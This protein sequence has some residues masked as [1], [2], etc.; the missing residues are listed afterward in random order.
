MELKLLKSTNSV[1]IFELDKFG[2]GNL[3]R[4]SPNIFS[5]TLEVNG[6]PKTLSLEKNNIFS[7]DFTLRNE[8]DEELHLGLGVHYRGKVN[9]SN[10]SFV[11]ISFFEEE[12]FGIIHYDEE[13]YEFFKE[14]N[15]VHRLIPVTDD[16]SFSCGNEYIN[17]EIS[18]ELRLIYENIEPENT[19][20]KIGNLKGLNPYVTVTA[21]TC[22]NVAWEVDY[23]IYSTLITNSI[24]PVNYIT[25]FFNASKTLFA[26]DGVE[27]Q[28]SDLVF[29]TTGFS[30]YFGYSLP[31]VSCNTNL[32]L[33]LTYLIANYSLYYS[34]NNKVPKGDVQ[35]LLAISY[36]CLSGGR[37][38]VSQ[39]IGGLCTSSKFLFSQVSLPF[40]PSSS[41]YSWGVNVVTHEQG[42]MFGSQHTHACA[43]NG[44]NTAIDRC[45]YYPFSSTATTA[46]GPSCSLSVTVPYPEGGTIMSYC[47]N[48]YF[49]SIMDPNRQFVGINFSLGFGPQP[50][51]VIVNHINKKAN[52]SELPTSWL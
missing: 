16:P 2:L 29:W 23:D 32:S 11:A 33:A 15:L 50:Q 46:G 12:V 37:A 7:N 30:P 14:S 49:P 47:Q 42:H 45:A 21:N 36:T 24:D 18:E 40:T 52:P 41:N 26:N 51:Q 44:N 31:A 3:C 9:E 5:L 38:G 43:W 28:L 25:S 22:I 19:Q 34:D 27:V 35:H 10:S 39:A 6:L 8:R 13:K 48:A 17:N 1:N 20:K 4:T